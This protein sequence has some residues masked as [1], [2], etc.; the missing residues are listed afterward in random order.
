ME[1]LKAKPPVA[2]ECFDEGLLSGMGKRK[3][4]SD[5]R[6]CRNL[7]APCIAGDYPHIGELNVELGLTVIDK[8]SAT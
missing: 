7:E 6:A 5:T 3:E 2:H 8:K 1:H 4:D